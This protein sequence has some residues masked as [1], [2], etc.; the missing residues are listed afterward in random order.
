M[1]PHVQRFISIYQYL[2]ANPARY[3]ITTDV[4][5]VVFQKNP[6]NWL[7]LYLG[8]KTVA[9]ASECLR[10]KDEPWGDNNIKE[11]FGFIKKICYII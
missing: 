1:A 5:D 7:D 9:V 11:T 6:I 8:N 4:R 3:V 10:Y 2:S